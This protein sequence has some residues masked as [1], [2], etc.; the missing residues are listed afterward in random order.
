MGCRP[1]AQ[2]SGSL[3]LGV[4]SSGGKEKTISAP[5]DVEVAYY[6][7]RG[8]GPDSAVFSQLGVMGST[9]VQNSIVTGAWTITV[10]AFNANHA[11]IGAGSTGVTVD[12]GVTALRGMFSSTRTLLLTSGRISPSTGSN[13]KAWT[14]RHRSTRLSRVW[15]VSTSRSCDQCSPKPLTTWVGIAWEERSPMK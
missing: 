4:S 12:P 3:V 11:P 9:V 5:L 6:D 10:D 14:G 1:L 15:Q 2:G 8:A 7:V 13:P